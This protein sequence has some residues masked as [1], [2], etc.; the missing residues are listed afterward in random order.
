[1]G[2]VV[3]LLR[4][5]ECVDLSSPMAGRS[6]LEMGRPQDYKQLIN[7]QISLGVN[8]HPV[9]FISIIIRYLVFTTDKLVRE[10]AT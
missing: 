8:K 10:K 6:E 1:V 4:G 2:G 9:A 5:K 7:K 3:G